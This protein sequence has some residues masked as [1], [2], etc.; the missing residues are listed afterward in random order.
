MAGRRVRISAR[1]GLELACVNGECTTGGAMP[2]EEPA[3]ID[4]RRCL[5]PAPCSVRSC[6]AK[7]TMIARS[8][9]AGG[10]PMEAIRTMRHARRCGGGSGARKGTKDH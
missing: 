4:L 6:R 3:A 5:Y 8:V 9:D 7:A 1:N 2:D 10:R